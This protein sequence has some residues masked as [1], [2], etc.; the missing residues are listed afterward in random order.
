MTT[1][2]FTSISCF[3]LLI[4]AVSAPAQQAIPY[5]EASERALRHAS[6]EWQL[7]VDH[8]PDAASATPEV[9]TRA[10]DILRARRMPEDA[11]DFYGYALKRGGNEATLRNQMGV[12]L[13][14]LQRF[15]DARASFARAVKLSPKTAQNWNNL[16]AADYVSGRYR[17]ALEE[18]LRAVK[19]NK[20]EAVF[21]S[22]LGTAY[23]ELKDFESARSQF[24]TAIKLDPNVFQ[25]GGFTGVQAHIL[26]ASD[27]GRFNFEMAKMSARQHDDANVIRWL[28]RSA[29]SGFDVRTEMSNDRDFEIYRKDPRVLTLI[30]TGRGLHGQVADSRPTPLLPDTAN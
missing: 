25:N 24:L 27:R 22:N 11:L 21:H 9:L 5:D 30:Q 28:A 29:E 3:S 12:T 4:C 10:A 23:F 18:Y 8:L 16:G 17:S 15:T 6:A 26:G 2:W 19:L 20:K 7:V 13:L 1:R 14:E